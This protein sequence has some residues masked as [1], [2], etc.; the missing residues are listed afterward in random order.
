M[1][2]VFS[3]YLWDHSYGFRG[4]FRINWHC[5][6]SFLVFLAELSVTGNHFPQELSRKFCNYSYMIHCWDQ[7]HYIQK[8]IFQGIKLCNVIDHTYI[9]KFSRELVC[10]MYLVFCCVVWSVPLCCLLPRL[11]CHACAPRVQAKSLESNIFLQSH[12]A[13]RF[14]ALRARLHIKMGR[15]NLIC[16]IDHI[17]QKNCLGN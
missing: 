16:V 1:K 3:K 13:K 12:Y 11:P 5:G 7:N 15:I 9:V 4:V 10:V 17:T 2:L 8:T 14:L 6:Y